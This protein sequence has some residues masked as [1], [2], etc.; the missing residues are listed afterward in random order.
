MK[1]E[2]KLMN[3]ANRLDFIIKSEELNCKSVRMNVHPAW[4]HTGGQTDEVVRNSKKKKKKKRKKT[5]E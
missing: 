1:T 4:L 3:Y 5:Y 2:K